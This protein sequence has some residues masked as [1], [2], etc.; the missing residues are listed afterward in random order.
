MSEKGQT[1]RYGYQNRN[2]QIN[3]GGTT[4]PGTDYGQSVYVLYCPICDRNYGSNGSDIFQRKCPYHQGGRPG[5][6]LTP[7]EEKWA[8]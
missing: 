7:D 3:L 1:T 8:M 6:P 4:R 2:G 5:L